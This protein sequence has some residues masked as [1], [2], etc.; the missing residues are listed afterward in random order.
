LQ[1]VSG[2]SANIVAIFAFT[3]G[4]IT[5]S[6]YLQGTYD[7]TTTTATFIAGAWID[8]PSGSETVSMSGTGRSLRDARGLR[9]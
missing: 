3:F 2:G 6:F 9:R 7:P 5:G 1:I 4:S 8:Q